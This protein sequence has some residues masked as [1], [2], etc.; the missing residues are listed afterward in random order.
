MARLHKISQLD[1]GYS[2]HILHT[3]NQKTLGLALNLQQRH[4][5]SELIKLLHDQGF[6]V[7]HCEVIRFRKSAASF[8]SDISN[9]LHQAMSLIW[10]MVSLFEWFYNL[11]PLI[12]TPNGRRE[13][14]IMAYEFQ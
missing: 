7:S 12:A 6:I 11:D 3:R 9:A 13:T 1:S 2:G 10:R 4:G 5:S 8:V 14:H